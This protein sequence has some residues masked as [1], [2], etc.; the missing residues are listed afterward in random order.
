MAVIPRNWL[1]WELGAVGAALG[2][3]A[4][5]V[6]W[7]AGFSTANSGRLSLS[8]PSLTASRPSSFSL[9]PPPAPCCLEMGSDRPSPRPYPSQRLPRL[10]ACMRD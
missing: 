10:P 4:H 7:R 1:G 8:P 2:L 5:S 9:P 3:G 6:L